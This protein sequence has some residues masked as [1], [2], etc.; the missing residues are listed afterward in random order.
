MVEENHNA[1]KMMRGASGQH[2]V[3][4]VAGDALLWRNLRPDGLGL[5]V[6]LHSGCPVLRGAKKVRT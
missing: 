3:P 1:V 6:S 4:P 5:S 2:Q